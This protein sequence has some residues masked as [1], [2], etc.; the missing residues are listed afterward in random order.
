MGVV[1]QIKD[2]LIPI[3][4]AF[5]AD[6]ILKKA[7]ARLGVSVIAI[8]S[9]NLKDLAKHVVDVVKGLY[10]ESTANQIEQKLNVIV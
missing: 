8:E 6:A 4:G 1:D 3:M 9:T 7:A 5:V 2:I 10:G